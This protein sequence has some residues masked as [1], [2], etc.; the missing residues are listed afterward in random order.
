MTRRTLLNQFTPLDG[1]AA[2]LA[3]LALGGVLWSPKL[4]NSVAKATGALIPIQLTVDVRNIPVADPKALI[5]AALDQGKTSIVIRNQPAGSLKL[6]NI[7]DL[8]SKLVA[9]QPDGSVVT[10]IDPNIAANSILEARFVLD[11]NG[12]FSKNGIVMAGTNLKIGTPVELEGTTYRING[13][14]S[15]I[16]AK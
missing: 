8:T 4:S 15:N 5:Q 14:V 10:A 9:V 12:I 11:G 3:L 1:V 6:S 13:N 16:M 2:L 7:V